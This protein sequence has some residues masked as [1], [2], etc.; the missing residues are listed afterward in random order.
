MVPNKKNP[1]HVRITFAP[2]CEVHG[3]QV[4]EVYP[5]V[6]EH[7][8]TADG[9]GYDIYVRSLTRG[10][11]VWLSSREYKLVEEEQPA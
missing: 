9:N 1:T 2:Q 5:T 3:W 6:K 7:V 4:N 11:D 10:S 8:D